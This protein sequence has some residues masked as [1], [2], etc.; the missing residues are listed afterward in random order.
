MGP[1]FFFI[2]PNNLGL[3]IITLFFITLFSVFSINAQNDWENELVNSKNR[4]DARATSY[5]Y[6]SI[7]D[8]LN[9][10]KKKSNLVSLNGK[11]K[12]HF[13]DDSNNRPLDFFKEDFDDTSWK[14]IKVPSNWER[15]GYGQAIYTNH[16]YPFI[17]REPYIDREN[18]VG[19]YRRSFEV[20]ENWNDKRI[21]LHFG[22][23]S[24]AYYVWL[25]GEQIGYAED[26]CLPSEFDITNYVKDGKN[27]LAVQVFRWS[28]GSY[29]EDQDHWRLS[30]IQREVLLLAQPKVA[31][32]DFTIRTKFDENF[33]DAKLQIRPEI[34]KPDFEDVSGWTI[35]TQLVNANNQNVLSEDLSISVSE[36]VNEKYPHRDNVDFAL[37]ERNIVRPEKWS[38]EK[39]YL[40]TLILK[41][42]DDAD[43]LQ[44]VRTAKVGFR[45]VR[46]GDNQSLLV[47]GRS[48]LLYGVNRHDHDH[49]HGKALTR[50]DM[51][52]D[53]ELMKQYNFNAVRTSHYPNDPYFYELCD[54][55][56]LYVMDEANLETHQIGGL[57]S[58]NPSWGASFL[59]R[60][61]RMVE[62]DKNHSSIIFW[63]LGNESGYGSNHTAMGAWIKDFDP[64]RLLHYEGAQGNPLTG[65]HLKYNSE[66]YL[67]NKATQY[68][69][70]DDRPIVDVL[71]RMYLNLN[72]L[73]NLAVNPEITRPV[74]MCEYA[75][76]MGNSM[77]NMKEYWD[78]IRSKNRLIGGFIWDWIDQGLLEK[79]NEVPYYA[80]GGDYGDTPNDGNFCINGIVTSDR[81]PKP[82]IEECKYVYQPVEFLPENLSE[83]VFLVSNRH[84]FKNLEAYEFKY[85]IEANGRSIS[86]G[87]FDVGALQ[88]G[89]TKTIK[90]SYNLSTIKPNT[91]YWLRVSAHLKKDNL[92]ASKGFEIAK[93]QFELPFFNSNSEF[94]KSIHPIEVAENDEEIILKNKLF[95]L[96]FNKST[97]SIISLS[98]KSKPVI[99]GKNRPYFWRPNTDNDIRGWLPNAKNILIWKDMDAKLKV[100]NID[101]T[102]LGT[103][104]YQIGF[105]LLSPES[106]K[107]R[108]NYIV[109]GDGEINVNYSL[110]IPEEFPEMLRVGMQFQVP[111]LHQDMSFFGKGPFENYSDRSYG[112]EVDLYAGT[113]NDFYFHYVR[114]QESSN[115]TLVN[116]LALEDKKNGIVF[117]GEKPLSV[118]VWPYNSDNINKAGHVYDLIKSDVLTVNIDM[119]QSGIGGCDSWTINAR[120][121]D[122][123]RLLEKQYSYSF[124]IKP[125]E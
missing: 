11:W 26:S 25:N 14:E 120:P 20:P 92:Y 118:S 46:I 97:G 85:K 33:N 60:A 77:G 72:Q 107:L 125:K 7:D 87:T 90:L 68:A 8:A 81:K 91:H 57:L 36:I 23:V 44:E 27:Q 10:D 22:G 28:D 34:L 59:E 100:V 43:K 41:L 105:T 119:V 71:S 45:D 32:N 48:V 13:E 63:S 35:K 18:A 99:I 106:V 110:D 113:V 75:H 39:P 54:L 115:F 12:F 66:A 15:E 94:K 109:R 62:R 101:R 2:T 70:P 76:A 83:G 103:S 111:A 73:E 6:N 50:E 82:Q 112:A 29:L 89:E 80:Y 61:Y 4:M 55:Y 1:F 74:M 117:T 102:E 9:G 93:Q 40:Y 49:I 51:K 104:E 86:N 38:A 116:W 56:G 108:L 95:N 123:Y 79:R 58:N 96:V 31:I 16:T 47:N 65:R 19:S 98:Y 37:L 17:P 84:F 53:V 121:I 5:S 114:P 69:N 42:Y 30:G 3:K 24:S 122:K 67:E 88:P 124:T 78:V 64:T 21:I 52:R